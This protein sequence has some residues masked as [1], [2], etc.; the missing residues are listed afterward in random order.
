MNDVLEEMLEKVC[1]TLLP[2]HLPAAIDERNEN[3]DS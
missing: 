1:F 3:S 2:C